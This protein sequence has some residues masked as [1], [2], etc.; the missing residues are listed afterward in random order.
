MILRGART[1]EADPDGL[2]KVGQPVA[3]GA[4]V[5]R[6]TGG[7]EEAEIGRTC[8]ELAEDTIFTIR[9]KDGGTGGT[10][11]DAEDEGGLWRGVDGDV[12]LIM[13]CAWVAMVF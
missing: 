6:Q 2:W 12:Y 7:R 9:E 8:G 3:D 1:G 10:A 5:L 13:K 4:E 11:L